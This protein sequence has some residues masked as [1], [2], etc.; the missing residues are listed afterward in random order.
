M[1]TT[2]GIAAFLTAK[3]AKGLTA[4]TIQGYRYRLTIFSRFHRLLPTKPEQMGDHNTIVEHGEI[5]RGTLA[6]MLKQLGINR[7]DF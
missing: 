4:Q 6:T 2:D 1:N 3:T 5:P 7:R